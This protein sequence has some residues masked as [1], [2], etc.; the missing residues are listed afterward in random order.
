[1]K[2]GVNTYSFRKE[3]ASGALNL[4]QV[5][6]TISKISEIGGIELLDKHI[7]SEAGSTLSQQI[8]KVKKEAESKNLKIYAMGPHLKL[9]QNNKKARE[10]EIQNFKKWIDAA[11]ENGIP[12]LRMQGGRPMF[13][14]DKNRTEHAISVYNHILKEVVPYAENKKVKLGLE[15]HW[16]HTSQP[17]FLKRF[18]EEFG[19]SPSIGIIFDWGNFFN[20]EDRFQAL[21]TAAL[22]KMHIHNHVK[23]FNFDG[24]TGLCTDWDAYMIVDTFRKNKFSNYFSIEYEG[25]EDG[26]TGVFKSVE[27]LKYCISLKQHNIDLNTDPH[28]LFPKSK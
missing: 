20:N 4:S 26:V 11:S 12:A 8:A 10:V 24:T 7:P 16:A 1:M 6:E 14:W 21:E 27:V 13:F 3:L 22:P 25:K 28:S 18:S 2:I 19:G 5:L 9:W 23:M 17:I 15:T